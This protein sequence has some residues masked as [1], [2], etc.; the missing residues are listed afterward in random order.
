MYIIYYQVAEAD[1][2]IQQLRLKSHF[3]DNEVE[4]E[5]MGS[6]NA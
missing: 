2:R 5:A 6:H 3:E 4:V 1:S